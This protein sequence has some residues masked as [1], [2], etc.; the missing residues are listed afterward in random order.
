MEKVG[1]W[2]QEAREA[3]GTTLE[4]AE[5]ATRIRAQFLELLEAGDFAAFPGGDVQVRGFLR[6]YARH[7][8]LPTEEALDRYENE[9]DG[10]GPLAVEALPAARQAEP[11]E[12]ADD[13]TVIRFRPRDIPVSSS[14]PRWMSV[15]TVLIV[16]IVLTALLVILAVVS[17]V[18]NRPD[19]E[20]ALPSSATPP[21]RI[22]LALTMD[23]A[24]GDLPRLSSVPD[25][26]KAALALE[27][28]AD[29]VVRIQR[30]WRAVFERMTPPNRTDTGPGDRVAPVEK[31]S[32]AA[33]GKTTG[34]QA[35]EGIHWPGKAGTCAWSPSGGDAPS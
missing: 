21:A 9:V 22:A 1:R 23:S 11:A 33:G 10:V 30:G 27:A 34:R 2:L 7:L 16:G 12:S 6:I 29:V 31:D 4:E 14:L 20:Q 25:G 32:A 24:L 15:E 18:M 35:Q 26:G 8:D 17:Y 13:L 19:G 3:Q 28:A 5:A